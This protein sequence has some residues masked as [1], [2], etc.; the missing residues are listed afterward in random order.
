MNKKVFDPKKI[1]IL[2]SKERQSYQNTKEILSLLDLKRDYIVA[3]LGCGSGVFTIPLSE[4]VAKVF[5]IDIEPKM[6]EFVNQKILMK[7][8][9][10]ITTKLSV[11]NNIP[12]NDN[13]LDLVLTVNTL[14][15]FSDLAK[16]V[17]EINRVLKHDGKLCVVDF[18][19]KKEGFGPPQRIRI[20]SRKAKTI[21][22]NNNFRIVKLKFLR[23]DYF[24]LLR[25]EF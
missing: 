6:L 2:E 16:T 23:F 14:H 9:T 5:A 12:I 21:F 24:L 22:L 3:D 11:N 18:K 19:K 13:V 4:K 8:I 15:E 17:T 20:S 1:H 7:R 10:N 25:K